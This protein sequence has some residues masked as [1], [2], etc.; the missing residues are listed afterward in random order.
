VG[1]ETFADFLAALLRGDD[2]AVAELSRRHGPLV[3]QVVRLRLRA[4][5]LRRVFD[6]CDV[7]QSVLR[8]FLRRISRGRLPIETEEELCRFL[9]VMALNN[10][11]TKLRRE[12]QQEVLPADWDAPDPHPDPA[13]T[14]ETSDLA[15]FFQGLMTADE[16]WL[17]QQY[18]DGIPWAEIAETARRDPELAARMACR[19]DPLR[20]RLQRIRQRVRDRCPDEMP[21]DDS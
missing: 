14:A 20:M 12:H 15:A 11:R 9:L 4:G 13:Q 10:L 1:F 8:Q 16:F 2:A 6:S 5:R 18:A 17:L 19:P 21:R 7:W 3:R